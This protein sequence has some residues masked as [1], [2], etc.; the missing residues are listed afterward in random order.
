MTAAT[1]QG[2]HKSVVERLQAMEKSGRFQIGGAS[3]SADG[4]WKQWGGEPIMQLRNPD[5]PQAAS[6]ILTLQERIEK[7][8]EALTPS[9]DTKADYKGE[10]SFGIVQVDE[11]GDENTVKTYVPWTTIKEI[12]A[13]I[14]ARSTLSPEGEG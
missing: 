5:G 8:T 13:A 9:S 1:L 4:Q 12:M 2:T 10:F 7:L 3:L 6:L 14:L 11:F